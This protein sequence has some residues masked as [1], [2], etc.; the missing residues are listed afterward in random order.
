LIALN[1][2][3]SARNNNLI[4]LNRD[5]KGL[6]RLAVKS[7]RIDDNIIESTILNLL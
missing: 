1:E 4:R 7:Y 6:L 2:E 5:L 3:I